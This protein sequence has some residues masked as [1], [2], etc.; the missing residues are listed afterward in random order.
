MTYNTG[1]PAAGNTP[2]HDQP[3]MQQNFTQI[4]TSYNTDHIALNSGS[5]AGFSNKTTLV[6]QGSDPANVV[7]AGIAY[8]KAVGAR[9]ELFYRPDGGP[10]I[11][12]SIIKAWGSFNG[13]NGAL[14]DSNNVSMVTRTGAG[15]Y[16]VFFTTPLA[17]ANF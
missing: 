13:A 5:N 4:A 14:F 1:I 12:L 15:S 3:L 7:N 11:E 9:T 10:I 16:T 17:N 2:A 8:T 6:Q